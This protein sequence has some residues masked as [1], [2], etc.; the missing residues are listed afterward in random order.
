[1]LAQEVRMIARQWV[2]EDASNTAGFVGAFFMGS[3]NFLPDNAEFSTTSDID[4]KIIL[5]APNVPEVISKVAYRGLVLD[6]SYSSWEEV[7][8]AEIVLANYYLACH[9]ARPSIISDPFGR[10]RLIQPIVAH[11]YAKRKWVIRRSEHARDWLLTSLTWLDGAEPLHDQVFA[12]LYATSL[13]SHIVLVADLQN[14]TTRKALVA[15]QG[16]LARYGHLSLHQSLLGLLGS[17]MMSREK[18]EALLVSCA[19]AFDTAK[20]FVTTPFFGD[21]SVTDMA[22]PMAIDG[23]RELITAGFHR[24]AVFWVAVIHTWCQKALYNDAPDIVRA[25]YVS[26]YEHLLAELGI[27]GPADLKVRVEQLRTAVP[28]VLEVA[29][30]IIAMNPAIED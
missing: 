5:D 25:R 26:S 15:S 2:E 10:L 22:R 30:T 27:S 6:T 29:E 21:T 24:E 4:I 17:A 19:D 28:E 7:R 23:A 8:S 3:T 1:M 11:E 16:V 9:L 18:A 13:P 12:W 20:M 14:P